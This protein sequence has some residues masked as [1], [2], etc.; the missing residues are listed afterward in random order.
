MKIKKGILVCIA[1][2]STHAKPLS[3]KIDYS[4]EVRERTLLLLS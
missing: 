3:A 1:F 4:P 2:A